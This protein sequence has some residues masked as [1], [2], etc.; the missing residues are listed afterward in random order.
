MQTVGQDRKN[1][2]KL[3]RQ[4]RYMQNSDP[5]LVIVL[6][7]RAGKYKFGTR[8]G[9]HTSGARAGKYKLGARAGCQGQ[10]PSK[11]KGAGKYKYPLKSC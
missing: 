8:E 4:G 3:S 9:K 1:K 10:G 11:G 5:G 2:H 6:Q 7:T